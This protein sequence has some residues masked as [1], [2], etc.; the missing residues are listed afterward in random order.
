MNNG[1]VLNFDKL[2]IGGAVSHL[3]AVFVESMIASNSNRMNGWRS[4]QYS[5]SNRL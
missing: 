1:I 4:V 2:R 3:H 5:T